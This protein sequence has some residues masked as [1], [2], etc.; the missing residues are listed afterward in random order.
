[1]ECKGITLC[2]KNPISKAYVLY[3]YTYIT[4]VK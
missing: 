3:D 1:M 2:V 4:L